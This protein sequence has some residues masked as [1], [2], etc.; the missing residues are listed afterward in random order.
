MNNTKKQNCKMMTGLVII[1][2]LLLIAIVGC[3][4]TPYDTEAMNIKEKFQ[5]PSITHLMGTDNFGRDIFSRVVVGLKDTIF[6]SG[7]TT[8]CAFV[9]GLLVGS[10]TG[11]FGGVID[12]ILMRINDALSSVPSVLLAIV[13]VGALGNGTTTLMISLAIVFIPSYARMVRSDY[14]KEKNKDYV[15]SG[16]LS[17]AN[18]FRLMYVHILP[19]CKNTIISA[20][21]VGFNNAILAEASLSFLGIGV[22]PPKASLGAM[23][24]DS[25]VFVTTSPWYSVFPGLIIVLLVIGLVLFGD[26][27][28]QKHS[29]K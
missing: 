15:L 18:H 7:V 26:G 23:L 22:E 10:V 2:I 1:G 28:K 16:R 21:V 11:Y 9:I 14:L 19:N 12:E 4:Y 8:L 17:G 27:Y 24:K 29:S 20:L 13:M 5:A 3:F 6:I 25:Q